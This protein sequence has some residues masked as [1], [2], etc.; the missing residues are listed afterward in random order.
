M[1]IGKLL[2]VFGIELE[3]LEDRVTDLKREAIPG[4]SRELITEWER[5]LALP[6][7]CSNLSG[8]IEERAQVAHAKYTG[9]YFGQSAQF[10]I[11]YAESLGADIT[12]KQYSGTGSAFRVDTNR[13]DRMPGTGT[14]DQRRAGSRLWSIGT[15]Y[16]WL[17]T[18]QTVTG[19]VSEDEIK[20]RLRQLAPAHTVIYFV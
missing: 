12:V 6:D 14:P 4:L 10:Y 8:T 1:I 17:V 19:E 20:C 3:C 5:D 7:I 16:K 2:R 18:I 13:V 11:D 9:L 15:V